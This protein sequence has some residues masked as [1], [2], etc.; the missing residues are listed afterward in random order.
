ME[1]ELDLVEISIIGP[2]DAVAKSLTVN[3]TV[4]RSIPTRGNE[5]FSFTIFGYNSKRGVKL[6]Y[7]TKCLE[8]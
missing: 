7:L 4:V 6:R 5:L 3:S 8:N 2:R 1:V